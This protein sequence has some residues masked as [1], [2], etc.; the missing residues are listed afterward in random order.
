MRKCLVANPDK[1]WIKYSNKKKYFHVQPHEKTNFLE[2]HET[3]IGLGIGLWG[4]HPGRD[5]SE[6][7]E[8]QMC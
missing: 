1:F 7:H 3:V 5:K 2:A 8:L 6:D 4:F